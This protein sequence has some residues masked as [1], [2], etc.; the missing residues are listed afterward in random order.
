MHALQALWWPL[1]CCFFCCSAFYLPS[2]A[3]I[4]SVQDNSTRASTKCEFVSSYLFF[5]IKLD[6]P[7][8][9]SPHGK[10]YEVGESSAKIDYKDEVKVQD[11]SF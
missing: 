2:F 4:V 10:D 5:H 11:S 6:I 7:S 9:Y 8:C 1:R 3:S